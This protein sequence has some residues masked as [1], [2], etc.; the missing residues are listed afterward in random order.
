MNTY[1]VSKEIELEDHQA[2]AIVSD[3]DVIA[4]VDADDCKTDLSELL[5]ND[6]VYLDVREQLFKILEDGEENFWLID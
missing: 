4:L 1:Q 6:K 5:D 3:G 2:F